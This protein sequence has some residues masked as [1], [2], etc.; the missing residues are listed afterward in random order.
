MMEWSAPYLV[1]AGIV[2]ALQSSHI[3]EDMQASL[4]SKNVDCNNL[5]PRD[6]TSA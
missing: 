5:G 3:L 4:R 1:I 2:V 6:Q